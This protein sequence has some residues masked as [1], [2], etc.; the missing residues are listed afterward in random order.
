MI[1]IIP[2]GAGHLQRTAITGSLTTGHPRRCRAFLRGVPLCLLVL[3]SSPQVRGILPVAY[4]NHPENGIIPAGAG[5]F[6]RGQVGACQLGDHPR[7]CEA[8]VLI[9]VGAAL[10]KGSSPQVRGIYLTDQPRGNRVG[11]IPAGAGHFFTIFDMIF[12]SGSSPQVR[13]I[14]RWYQRELVQRGIIPAGAGHF[15]GV[16]DVLISI[17]DHPR[18]CGAFSHKISRQLIRMGSSPQVRGISLLFSG[19]VIFCR[20]IPAGA[21]HLCLWCLLIGVG[22]DHPRRCG[23]FAVTARS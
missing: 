9:A 22:W 2:A 17:W 10:Y 5:H 13:G 19:L 14:Y 16:G 4:Q 6:R 18:R 1:G 7:R 3:G 12:Y 20:I 15:H 11:I 23:A 21:G 8:F